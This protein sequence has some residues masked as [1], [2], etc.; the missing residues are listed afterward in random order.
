M[1]GPRSLRTRAVHL[2]SPPPGSVP[3][4][5]TADLRLEIEE[6]KVDG[7]V[8]PGNVPELRPVLGHRLADQK[9]LLRFERAAFRFFPLAAEKLLDIGT[10]LILDAHPPTKRVERNHD[11]QGGDRQKHPEHDR[12]PK[13]PKERTQDVEQRRPQEYPRLH[14]AVEDDEENLRVREAGQT[15]RD[16]ERRPAEPP[17]NRVQKPPREQF[18]APV[19]ILP[20]PGAMPLP[21]RI[22]LV[23]E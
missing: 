7:S 13:N 23:A 5:R 4:V 6:A 12:V 20:I 10:R 11:A 8:L 2:F 15:R 18:R 19:R 1:Q 9:T 21:V 16:L 17:E 14:E 3:G 22:V